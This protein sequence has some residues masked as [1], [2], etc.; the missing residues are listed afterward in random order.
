MSWAQ[1]AALR[2]DFNPR[3]IGVLWDLRG[4]WFAIT[5]SARVIE[6]ASADGLRR[7]LRTLD[8]TTAADTQALTIGAQ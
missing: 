8:G 4:R 1:L 7:A 2:A 6:A 5:P 3:G